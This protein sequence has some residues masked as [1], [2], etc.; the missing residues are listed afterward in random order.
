MVNY[1]EILRLRSLSYGQRQVAASTKCS[2]D[3]V[4]TVYKL[5]DKHG[6][7]WP[8]PDD[9]SNANIRDLFYPGRAESKRR[10]P[11]CE[12]IFHE[13]AKPGVT[14]TLMWAEHSKQCHAEQVIPLKYTQ[15]CDYIANMLTPLKQLCESSVSPEKL[16]RWTGRA[17][18]LQSMTKLLV[19]RQLAIYL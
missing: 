6:L 5:F 3:T 18:L 15:F 8:L 16:W 10:I 12:A 2:R 4:S 7:Q 9:L 11:D 13:M 17:V 14:L 19:R 1:R